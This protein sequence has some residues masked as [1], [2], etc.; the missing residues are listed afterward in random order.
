MAEQVESEKP[1]PVRKKEEDD[2]DDDDEGGGDDGDD[3]GD[4]GRDNDN[5]T[6]Q[7]YC[8]SLLKK[9]VSH[10]DVVMETFLREVIDSLPHRD[11]LSSTKLSRLW[12]DEARKCI[13][14]FSMT[15]S[16]KLNPLVEILLDQKM[17]A[18][19]DSAFVEVETAKTSTCDMASCYQHCFNTWIDDVQCVPS[20]RPTSISG[21]RDIKDMFVLTYLHF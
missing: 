4:G 12:K 3:G 21:P 5:E 19:I 11:N 7:E 8:G 18:N 2:E 9:L 1:K 13:T 20:W 10:K 6:D 14:N 17:S 15:L 16:H